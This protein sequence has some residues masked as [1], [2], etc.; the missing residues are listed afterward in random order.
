MHRHIPK[1]KTGRDFVVGDIHGH[2]DLLMEE[3]SYSGFDPKRDRVFSVGDL[4]DRGPASLKCLELLD[5]PW[6]YTVRGNHEQMM[7]D[8]ATGDSFPTWQRNYGVWTAA[9]E[10]SEISMWI[11]RLEHL[12]IAMTIEVNDSTVGICHAEPCGHD[13]QAM[14]ADPKCQQQMMWGRKVL[15]SEVDPKPVTGIDITI[16]GHTPVPKP[17]RIGNRHFIDTGAGDGERLTVRNLSELVQEYRDFAKF[18]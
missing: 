12:P 7:I 11:S 4:I 18:L 2:F 13:W 6:F 9:L 14:T 1:N 15:R 17:R 16:H 8:W 3:L 10:P 5:K